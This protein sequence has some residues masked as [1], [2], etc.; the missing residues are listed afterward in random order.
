MKKQKQLPPA[1]S[2]EQDWAAYNARF[3][4]DRHLCEGFVQVKGNLQRNLQLHF[5]KTLETQSSSHLQ[6]FKQTWNNKTSGEQ[7]E[8]ENQVF[9]NSIL[10]IIFWLTVKGEQRRS[11]YLQVL[12]LDILK[13]AYPD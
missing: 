9:N 5:K 1:K 2:Y 7:T 10:N 13:S 4:A 3:E 8:Q 6:G 11:S 12:N